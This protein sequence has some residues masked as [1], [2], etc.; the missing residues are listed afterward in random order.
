MWQAL[1]KWLLWRDRADAIMLVWLPGQERGKRGAGQMSLLF[2]T[3]VLIVCSDVC[4][5]LSPWH[6]PDPYTMIGRSSVP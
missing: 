5:R 1:W 3:P 4:T 6:S 2:M